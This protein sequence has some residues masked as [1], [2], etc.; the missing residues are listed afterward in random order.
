MLV[1]LPMKLQADG[2]D[3]AARG[4]L[5]RPSISQTRLLLE[6]RGQQTETSSQNRF[7]VYGGSR[8]PEALRVLL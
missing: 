3:M 2:V 5:D 1:N 4:K 7:S 6:R 8:V